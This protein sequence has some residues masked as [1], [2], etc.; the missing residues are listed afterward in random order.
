[1]WWLYWADFS[2][3]DSGII[4]IGCLGR[5]TACTGESYRKDKASGCYAWALSALQPPYPSNFRFLPENAG[6]VY[7]IYRLWHD[8]DIRGWHQLYIIKR[9]FSCR[10]FMKASI[11]EC[12]E[13]FPSL[14]EE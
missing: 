1:M 5:Q 6:L 12:F 9:T 2:G 8:N 14:I 3:Y 13:A 4:Y 10:T 7:P 11:L